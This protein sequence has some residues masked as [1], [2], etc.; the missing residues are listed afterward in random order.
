MAEKVIKPLAPVP[1]PKEYQHLT[2]KERMLARY[3]YHNED[4]ELVKERTEAR[5]LTIRF[6]ATLPE[7]REVRKGILRELLSPSCRENKVFI[8]PPFQVDYGYNIHCGNNVE[9]NFGCIILDCVPV[10]IGDNCLLGPNV[11]IYTVYHPLSAENRKDDANYYELCT[12]VTIG[13]NVW[14]GGQTVILPGITVGDNSVIGASSVVTKDVPANVVVAGNPARI[15]R[16]MPQP[17]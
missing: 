17:E 7:E 13:R 5:K 1:D 15:L 16:H 2:H 12:P 9:M 11:Q 10:T 3:P 8:Q 6:N 4:A 14:I